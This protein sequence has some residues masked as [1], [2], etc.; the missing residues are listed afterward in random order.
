MIC[1]RDFSKP[2]QQKLLIHYSYLVNKSLEEGIMPYE[3]KI[4]TVSP[5]FKA[6]ERNQVKNYRPISLLSSNIQNIWKGSFQK[7]IYFH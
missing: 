2:Y 6:K 3:L 4:A 7:A 1:R 5:I